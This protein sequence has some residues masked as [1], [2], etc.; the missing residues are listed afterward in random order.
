MDQRI[1]SIPEVLSNR[2]VGLSQI[3]CDGASGSR[4]AFVFTG[5]STTLNRLIICPRNMV[6]KSSYVQVIQTAPILFIEVKGIAGDKTAK[7]CP[8]NV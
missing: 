7:W 3:R 8:E 4:F 6:W 2:Y 5:G 1:S